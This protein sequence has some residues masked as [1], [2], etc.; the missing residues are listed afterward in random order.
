LWNNLELHTPL[1]R[2]IRYSSVGGY[3]FQK[4]S[5]LIGSKFRNHRV[6]RVSSQSLF[7]PLS[8]FSISNN[9]IQNPLFVFVPFL[10][11]PNRIQSFERLYSY[12][13]I[14][15][16]E[17]KH[18]YSFILSQNTRVL[19]SSIFLVTIALT[20]LALKRG[21]ACQKHIFTL[22]KPRIPFN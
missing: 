20:F 11:S 12:S 2:R 18:A 9:R 17:A 22:P 1:A 19:S 10:M 13:I 8:V 4:S 15:L 7:T 16:F 14:R 3:A 6:S 5:I 21:T